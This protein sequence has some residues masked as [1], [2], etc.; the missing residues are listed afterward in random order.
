M[1]YKLS[2]QTTK[3]IIINADQHLSTNKSETKAEEITEVLYQYKKKYNNFNIICSII[4]LI[5]SWN[6]NKEYPIYIKLLY[7]LIALLLSYWYLIFY[8]IYYIYLH[9]KCSDEIAFDINFKDINFKDINFKDINFNQLQNWLYP[10]T[11]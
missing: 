10:Q 11:P 3:Q 5:L 7:G 6:C 1:S 2:N 8:V 4:A 9:K